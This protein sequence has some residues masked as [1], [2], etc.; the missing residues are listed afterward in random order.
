ML[1]D[2][3]ES[4]I[5]EGYKSKI[6]RL[7]IVNITSGDLYDA[8]MK[9]EDESEFFVQTEKGKISVSNIDSLREDHK[10]LMR[11]QDEIAKLGEEFEDF[12]DEMNQILQEKTDEINIYKY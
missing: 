12:G 10:V 5:S 3:L 4:R 9:I 1:K 8:L 11:L 2:I 7:S 6:Q